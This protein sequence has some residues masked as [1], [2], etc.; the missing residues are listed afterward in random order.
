MM[1]LVRILMLTLV[2]MLL[3]RFY[4]GSTNVQITEGEMEEFVQGVNDEAN[5][6][7]MIRVYFENGMCSGVVISNI[8]ALTAAH[9]AVNSFNLLNRDSI[10]IADINDTVLIKA[11]FIAVSVDKDVALIK[12]DFRDFKSAKVTFDK[13]PTNREALGSCGMPSNGEPVC[14][15][16]KYD[17]N[18]ML[19]YRA[20]DGNIF[21]GMSG[22]PV[23]NEDMEVIAVNSA[24]AEDF[25]I[26]SSLI[27]LRQEWGI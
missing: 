1:R 17:G 15:L 20:T 4:T 26:L 11:K 16:V 25:V 23:F 24:I 9:C 3:Y 2:L 8:Y 5:N 21:P 7:S 22:G 27:G 6:D 19:R 18:F 14:T 10:S 13:M 12:G